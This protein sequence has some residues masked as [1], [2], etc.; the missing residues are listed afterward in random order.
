LVDIVANTINV[1]LKL[2]DLAM[3]IQYCI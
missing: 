3:K 2:L 1:A